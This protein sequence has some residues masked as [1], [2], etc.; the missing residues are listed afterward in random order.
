MDKLTQRRLKA[1]PSGIGILC[2]WYIKDANNATIT[3]TDGREFIDFAG[4][5]A[6]L[7]TG[8]KHPK[9]LKA[10]KDQL[11]K[12]THTAYQITPYESYITLAEEINALVPINNPKTCFFCTGAEAVENAIKVARAYTKRDAVIAFGASFHGRTFMT[13]GLTGKVLPYKGQFGTPNFP[14]YHA[15]YPNFSDNVGVEEAIRSIERLFK[16]TIAPDKVAAIIYEPVQGEG[17]FNIANNE[18]VTALRAICDK[19][20]ILL[21]ADEVQSGFGRTG[22]MFASEYFDAKPDIITMAKS[23]AGGF[24]LSGISARAEVIDCVNKGGLGGTYAGNPISIAASLAVLEVF[25]EEKLLD[26]SNFLGDKLQAFLNELVKKENLVANVRGLGS[27]VAL[28]FGDAGLPNLDIASKV[29]ANAMESG[30][31]LLT[32][33]VYGNVIRFLYPLTIEEKTFDK[34]LDILKASILKALK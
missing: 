2:D 28:E 15:L 16:T 1:T 30:L 23:I 25:K 29:Q 33:G 7:N 34:A 17:G 8:H 27:M 24:V 12:F 6:V 10:V 4:G 26:R 3:S 21:I 14:V 11:D 13:M 22:K 20:G 5:I 19:H 9:V 31:L 32:C 18:F